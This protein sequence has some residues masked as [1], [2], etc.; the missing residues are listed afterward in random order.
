[1]LSVDSYFCSIFFPPS[2]C[3]PLKTPT[4]KNTGLDG[5]YALF[6]LSNI[7]NASIYFKLH[8]KLC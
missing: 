4:L 8:L 2:F 3:D 5:Q 6:A 1:M 7:T